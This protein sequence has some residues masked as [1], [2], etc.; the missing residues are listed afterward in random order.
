MPTYMVV[1]DTEIFKVNAETIEDAFLKVS[2]YQSKEFVIEELY[3]DFFGEYFSKK[4]PN[5]YPIEECFHTPETAQKLFLIDAEKN[6]MFNKHKEIILRL[7]SRKDPL[8]YWQEED[9]FPWELKKYIMNRPG[10]HDMAA[11]TEDEI[12]IIQ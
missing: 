1:D 6:K 4:D 12:P 8:E 9:P 2:Y 10:Y 11:Y 7:L 3:V 5:K